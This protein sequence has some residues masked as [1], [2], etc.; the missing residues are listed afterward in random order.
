VSLTVQN[1]NDA[2]HREFGDAYIERSA[3]ARAT[4]AF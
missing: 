3:F 2:R 4:W 1:L